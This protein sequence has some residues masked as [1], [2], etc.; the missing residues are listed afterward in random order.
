MSKPGQETEEEIEEAF[1][2][3]TNGVMPLSPFRDAPTMICGPGRGGTTAMATCFARSP[4][5]RFVTD[6]DSRGANLEVVGM[7]RAIS[8][9]NHEVLRAFRERTEREYCPRFF[10]KNPGF[11]I[12]QRKCP[13]LLNVWSGANLIVMSRDPL[14]LTQRELSVTN[15]RR[16]TKEHLYA[17][18]NRTLS[19]YSGAVMCSEFMGVAVVSYEKLVVNPEEV[20]RSL[21]EW[22]GIEVLVP[23]QVK[24]L[25]E[26][27]N[28]EYIRRQTLGKMRSKR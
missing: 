9:G 17:S 6:D 5:C 3:I 12:H 26:P 8:S 7:N 1:I 4:N 15:D 14:C 11:E 21:N 24:R 16:E 2:G 28:Y 13:E 23:S 27:N 20:A 19:S 10:F 18:A 22:M 25:V